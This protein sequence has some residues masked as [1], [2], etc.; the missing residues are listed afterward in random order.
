MDNYITGYVLGR[1]V[2]NKTAIT[3]L[4]TVYMTKEEIPEIED[5]IIYA[6]VH[7]RNVKALTFQLSYPD[8]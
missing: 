8:H 4:P 5:T 3:M 6:L 2:A 7:E 1:Y